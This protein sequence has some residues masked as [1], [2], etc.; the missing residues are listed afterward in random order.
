MKNKVNTTDLKST[1]KMASFLIKKPEIYFKQTMDL[2]RKAK[3]NLGNSPEFFFQINGFTIRLVFA[4]NTLFSSITTGFKHLQKQPSANFDLTVYCWDSF[5]TG[6]A[7]P[8][9]PEIKE[10]IGLEND[11]TFFNKQDFCF[12]YNHTSGVLNIINLNTNIGLFW[13]RCH[14]ELPIYEK[15]TALK[16]L[17]NW[18]FTQ[19][20]G[21]II[22][23][24]AIG[25]EDKG[26]LIGGRGR[27]GKSTTAM[28]CF[29][30]GMKYAGDDYVLL[31]KEE[32]YSVYSLYNSIKLENNHISQFFKLNSDMYSIDP[33]YKKMV[34]F[35]NDVD[36]SRIA[37]GFQ[38]CAV[39]IPRIQPQT[40]AELQRISPA[41]AFKEIA[42][43]TI[44]QQTGSKGK[45][46]KFLAELTKTI[47][48]YQL[49]LSS[50][51]TRIPTLIKEII[52]ES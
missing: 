49:S 21:Y 50:D 40:E 52:T 18:W 17:M 29:H 47:P 2:F 37:T 41:L 26:I 8:P 31:T 44:F 46:F 45:V 28:A 36:Q 51:I 25:I 24:A 19:Q 10:K 5:S 30:Q 33:F 7:F 16:N 27:V 11:I 42:P 43:S 13:I 4:G 48:C 38:I 3:Q 35:L 6:S 32:G 1:K 23:A 15:T 34:I 14:S 20:N 9:L 12:S 22:H 39:I